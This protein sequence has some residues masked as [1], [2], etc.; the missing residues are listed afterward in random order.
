[1]RVVELVADR[2][3]QPEPVAAEPVEARRC[4]SCRPRPRA[5]A[6]RSGRRCPRRGASRRGL[7]AAARRSCRRTTPGRTPGR[8]SRPP[9]A[10]RSPRARR[11]PAR[12]ER[13]RRPSP[14]RAPSEA[15]RPVGVGGAGAARLCPAA[16]RAADPA[17]ATACALPDDDLA[18]RGKPAVRDVDSARGAR[19]R[20]PGAGRIGAAA[21]A[22]LREDRQRSPVGER[23][24]RAGRRRDVLPE[25]AQ[26]MHGRHRDVRVRRA[27]ARAGGHRRRHLRGRDLAPE[28]GEHDRLRER[29]RGRRLA[30]LG[31]D[32]GARAAEAAR[33]SRR[34]DT[35]TTARPRSTFVGHVSSPS[36]TVSCPGIVIRTSVALAPVTAVRGGGAAD[37]RAVESDEDRAGERGET[38]HGESG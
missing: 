1:M 13:S 17:T 20:T 32:A 3:A 36:D 28:Q 10:A 18:T 14:A 4:G 8:R 29:L 22:V 33:S 7:P 9:R 26:P 27:G 16:G 19:R 37:A 35:G 38:N 6:P 11:A 25:R 30:G 15:R 21:P 23:R 2:V 12:P 24:A 5:A 34:P 31:R